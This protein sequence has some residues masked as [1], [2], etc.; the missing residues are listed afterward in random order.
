LALAAKLIQREV[1]KAGL[2]D[3]LGKAG[4]EN[5]QGEEVEKL[6]EFAQEVIHNAMDHGGNLCCMVSEEEEGIIP[7]PE[8]FPTGDYVLI[9]DPLDGSSNIDVN[10]SIGT[11]FSIFKKISHGPRGVESDCLQ[12]GRKQVAAGYVLYGSSTMLV[13]TVG[14]GV[15]GFTLDPSIGE[16]LLSHRDITLPDPP[17]RY[18]SVNEAY[19]Q[20]W[21]KGQQRMVACLKGMGDEQLPPFR[22]R[23]IGSLVADFH[24]TLFKG[25]IFMYPRDTASP[26]GK[27]R[28]LY[29]AAPLAFVCEQAGGRASDGEREIM[30]LQPTSLHQRTPLYLGSAEFVDMAEEFLRK[31]PDL[32]QK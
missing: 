27:L 4:K 21:A 17:Q 29:E 24:R 6:D 19:Y 9:F 14:R 7:I 1:A 10:V 3:I 12:P 23:Y 15:H 26:E 5:V 16:F 2:V 30:D 8:Q 32:P 18:Y 28:L 11:I 13:Y 22:S 31:D 20:R 25:G